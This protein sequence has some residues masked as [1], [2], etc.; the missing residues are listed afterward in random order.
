MLSS[1]D[2][3]SHK[4]VDLYISWTDTGQTQ[5]KE[6]S[7]RHPISLIPH[8]INL[9]WKLSHPISLTPHMINVL[10]KLLYVMKNWHYHFPDTSNNG[11][12]LLLK[13]SVWEENFWSNFKSAI[14]V[15]DGRYLICTVRMSLCRFNSGVSSTN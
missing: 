9:L 1:K 3:S 12:I 2:T 13:E 14:H 5:Q 7:S 11:S 8:I 6:E 10:W 4:I 15:T